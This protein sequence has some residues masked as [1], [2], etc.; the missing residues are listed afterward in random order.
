MRRFYFLIISLI[1]CLCT[2]AQELKV[3]SF[4]LA[5]NDLSASLVE[6]LRTDEVGNVCA[7][8]K[9]LLL[10]DISK[11]Q[12]NVIGDIRNFSSEKWV[13]LSKGTKEIRR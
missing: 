10:D 4:K 6:N 8:V 13:Y 3:K 2:F 12:G 7:L 9:I 5:S 11:V 1:I